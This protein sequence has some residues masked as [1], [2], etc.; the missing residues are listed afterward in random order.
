VTGEGVPTRRSRLLAWSLGGLALT[1]ALAAVVLS[2][3]VGWSFTDALDAFV[4]TNALIGVACAVCGSILATHRP[5]N[6][7]GWLFLASGVAQALAAPMA[8]LGMLLVEGGAHVWLVRTVETV[9]GWS[10]PWS[11]GL[12]LPLALLLFP[13]GRPPSPRWR[14]VVIAVIVTAPL[15]SLEM[16]AGPEAL[17]AG[18][19]PGYLKLP[20][21]NSLQWLWT[22]TEFRGLATIALG[23]AA[24][25]VR[26]RRGSDS[27][28][29]QLLWLMLAA[30][31]ALGA[32]IPWGLVAGTPVV[33]LFAFPLIPIAVTV[34]IVRHQLLDIRLVVS[35]A[36]AWL[37]LSLAVLLAYVAVLALLDR[38]VSAQFGR[39]A[40]VTVIMVLVAAPILPRLQRLVD[41]ALYGDRDNPA[42]VV[43][44]LGQQLATPDGD[45]RGIVAT[46]RTALRLPYVGLTQQRALL[47][48]DGDPPDPSRQQIWPL[49]YDGRQVGELT[50]GLRAGER[51]LSPAD[52]KV[53]AMLAAPIAVALQATAVSVQ[54]QAS[55]ERIVAAQAEERGR[56]RRDLHDGL[57]PTLT[58]IAFT[59]DAAANLL[60]SDRDQSAE[61]LNALRRDARAAL[62]DVRRI[63]E[64]LRPPVLD[65]LG[66]EG[67]LR[68]RVGRPLWRADGTPVTVQLELPERLPALPAG[69]EVATYRIATEALTN[70]LRHAQATRAVIEL[71]CAERLE[72]MITDDGPADHSWT[73]GVGLQTM[74]ERA[75]ELGGRFDAGPTPDGWRVAASFPLESVG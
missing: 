27:T 75:A 60:D 67:A 62:S 63:V 29:R 3:L 56:I 33:V 16:G 45:L 71:H 9:F 57:G 2:E 37:L 47:A 19:P 1:E 44:R 21:Y 15:F 26:Y 53:L 39:S 46:V 11:I 74:R 38:F 25:V 54:L 43:S 69:V 10:W 7:I 52:Q 6:P 72:V 68:Q 41:R 49:E 36:L 22:L 14:P 40:L 64:D 32:A 28:R 34:A 5:R 50:V 24:L 51:V 23:V 58:G 55:Q 35:R 70:V 18:V 30:M 4:V 42:V 73:P 20:F 31:V 17:S 65:E 66:L 48:G 12:F 8:P 59:A 13:D 61:L